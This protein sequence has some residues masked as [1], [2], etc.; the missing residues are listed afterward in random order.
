MEIISLR[1]KKIR[2]TSKETIKEGTAMSD[3]RIGFS[4]FIEP[5]FITSY[6]T[7]IISDTEFETLHSKYK[8][9]IL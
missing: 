9:E 3:I 7:Q 2:I 1:N 4:L 8:L 6:V 5:F